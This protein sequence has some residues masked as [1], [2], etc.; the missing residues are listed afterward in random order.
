[1]AEMYETWMNGQAPWSSIHD[2]LNINMSPRIRVSIGNPIY[3][4]GFDPCAKASNIARTSTMRHLS[5]SMTSNPL[6][7]STGPTNSVR[8]STMIFHVKFNM[9][10][11]IY[12]H[13]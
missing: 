8:N 7:V 9:I 4:P 11:I 5:T 3:P 1:M 6:F 2:Y 13:I 10:E 12:I